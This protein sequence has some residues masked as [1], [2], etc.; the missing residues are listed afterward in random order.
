MWSN[1]AFADEVLAQDSQDSI[2]T[3]GKSV[4]LKSLGKNH[5]ANLINNRFIHLSAGSSALSHSTA[6]VNK[7]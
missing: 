5:R 1:I 4:A 7:I 6:L 2:L 3:T